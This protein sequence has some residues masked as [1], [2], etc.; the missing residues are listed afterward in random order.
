MASA[1]PPSRTAS[2]WC[3]GSG[4]RNDGPRAN[5]AV[6][7]PAAGPRLRRLLLRRRHRSGLRA[8]QAGSARRAAVRGVAS[9]SPRTGPSD[10]GQKASACRSTAWTRTRFRGRGRPRRRPRTGR[11]VGPQLAE[12]FTYPGNKH[13]FTDS[14]LP[15][16]DPAATAL[17]LHRSVEFLD[18]PA[19]T[20]ARQ[21]ATVGL[22]SKTGEFKRDTTYLDGRITADGRDGWPVE[23]GGTGWWWR[24]LPVG[25]PD[26]DRPAAARA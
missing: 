6:D 8:D 20:G 9:R 21:P 10:R 2:P 23:P 14:S 7:R 16:Y 17:V 1:R 5:A 15:S 19:S 22:M 12:L 3:G 25:E 11:D 13:L 26:D 18:K 4:T 24:G